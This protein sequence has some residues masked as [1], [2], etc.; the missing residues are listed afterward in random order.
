MC[1]LLVFFFLCFK[2]TVNGFHIFNNSAYKS[3]VDTLLKSKWWF[4]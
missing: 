3:D 1:G 2:V 4:G